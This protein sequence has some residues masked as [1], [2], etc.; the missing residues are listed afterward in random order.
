MSFQLKVLLSALA[1]ILLHADRGTGLFSHIGMGWLSDGYHSVLRPVYTS[2]SP[3]LFVLVFSVG[4]AMLTSVRF[5][6]V[7]KA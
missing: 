2:M 6:R 4:L 1:L 3:V 7:H 5:N